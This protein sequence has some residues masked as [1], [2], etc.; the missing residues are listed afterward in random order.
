MKK[1]IK[2]GKNKLWA[3]ISSVSANASG[4]SGI[5]EL[6]ELTVANNEYVASYASGKSPTGRIGAAY[7]WEHE[8]YT[9]MSKSG[10]NQIS[11]AT[12]GSDFVKTGFGDGFRPLTDMSRWARDEKFRLVISREGPANRA[13]A[14]HVLAYDDN[15]GSK[16]FYECTIDPARANIVT[17]CIF[18]D[19][20]TNWAPHQ[21]L[22][23]E[24]KEVLPGVWFP[25]RWERTIYDSDGSGRPKSIMRVHVESIT[26]GAEPADAECTIAALHIPADVIVMRTDTHGNV[27]QMTVANGELVPRS[28]LKTK[29]PNKP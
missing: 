26:P 10:K 6:V 27:G 5:Q 9:V 13:A 4:Q 11:I 21:F 17:E 29:Q 22:K 23:V 15:L 8:A 7:V 28:L 25:A 1:H 3:E 12:D 20:Y 16:H 2:Q 19:T 18:Y 14:Y 24:P